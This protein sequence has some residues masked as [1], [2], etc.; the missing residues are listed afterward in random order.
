MSASRSRRAVWIALLAVLT[1]LTGCGIAPGVSSSSDSAGSVGSCLGKKS[2]QA[3]GS[4]AQ[5]DAMAVF[6]R[7][8]ERVCRGHIVTY[9][10]IESGAGRSDF[11]SGKTDFGGTDLP[12]GSHTGEGETASARC[13]G[14]PAWNLPV[15]FGAIAIIYNVP[16]VDSLV[17]DAPTAARIFNGVIKT[18]DAPEIATLNPTQLLP[19]QAITLISRG[20]A[21]GTTENFQRYLAVAAGPAWGRGIGEEFDGGTGKTAIGNEGVWAAMRAR[22]GSITYTAW[23]FAKRNGLTTADIVTSAGGRP[24]SLSTDSVSRSLA[25]VRI[26]GRGNDLILDP[27][28]AYLPTRLGA[29]PIVIISYEAVCSVYPDRDTSLA[30]KS[31]LAI[32]LGQ[33]Q[34]ELAVSGY[35][36]VPDSVAD[37]LAAAVSAIR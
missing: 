28:P 5:V 20:D 12:L 33:G 8:Y 22:M 32:A 25:A 36:P 37:R 9:S 34:L 18:W 1:V 29:Y 31:F 17:L 7:A 10:S 24:V 4:S 27:S 26:T 13:G 3:S 2:L 23:P 35:V 6:A 30:V 11:V 14:H 19:S 21:S 16:G 15:V